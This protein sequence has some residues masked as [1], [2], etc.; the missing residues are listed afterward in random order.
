MKR[1]SCSVLIILLIQQIC[2]T[3]HKKYAKGR[4]LLPRG[5]SSNNGRIEFE[6]TIV[7]RVN[8][9]GKRHSPHK[10]FVKY[11]YN[12][13][14]MATVYYRLAA[15]GQIFRFRLERDASFLSPALNVEHIYGDFRR[16]PFSGNLQHCFYRGE[17]QG[18]P[19]ST[20]VFNLCNGL[21]GSFVSSGQRYLI[22]PAEERN[23]KIHAHL[24]KFHIVFRHS[25]L[26]DDVSNAPSTCGLVDTNK[27]LPHLR[28]QPQRPINESY[29]RRRRKRSLGE[30]FVETLVVAD[31]TMVDAFDSK[32]DL[33][34]YIITLMGV[35]AQIYRDRSIGCAINIVVV[36]IAYL[37]TKNPGFHISSDATRTLK[38]FCRW[39][40][41]HMMSEESQSHR[42]DTAILLTRRDIC[43]SPGKCDTLGLA[44]LGT[45]CQSSRSCSLAEDNGLST[46]YTIA[47][48]LGHVFSLPHDGDNNL[49][50]RSRGDQHLMAPSLSFDSK[51][52][53][54]SSCSREKI[55]R[56]LELGYGSCLENKP[57]EKNQ[58]KYHGALPG[59]IYSV[60][61]QCQMI[62]GEESRLC[63]YMEPCRRLWC[64]KMIGK[65]KGCSTHHMPWADGTPCAKRKWCIKGQCVRKRKL[66]PVDGGW[67]PW[68]S[69]N[70]CTRKCGGGISFAYRKCN[71]PIP[72]NGGKYC[73]GKR[74]RFVSCNTQECPPGSLDF[75]ALQC[76][77][78]HGRRLSIG[79]RSFRPTR[80][81][82]KYA[83]IRKENQC[84]LYC[85]MAGTAIYFKLKDKVID[86]TPCNQETTDI[87]V[88]G[89]CL[90]AGCDRDL[91]SKKKFDK[92][93]VCGGDNSSCRR[94]S[95]TFNE[96]RFGYN[97]IFTIPVAS[98]DI[99]ITQYG[100]KNKEDSSYLA[101]QDQN[102]KFLLNGGMIVGVGIR[103][104]RVPGAKVWYSGSEKA[105]EQ[106]K[107]SGKVTE[108]IKVHVLEVGDVLPPNI[109]YSFNQKISEPRKLVYMWS[110][111]G[112]WTQC[113]K[114]CRGK[115]NRQ[116][117]CVRAIDKQQVSNSRC[118]QR[119]RPSSVSE[120]CN[121]S[122]VLEWKIQSSGECSARCGAGNQTR[123]VRCMRISS[124]RWDI[125][126]DKHC[127]KG[128]KP[129]VV[130]QCE[131]KCEGTK[132]VYSEWSK[133]SKSCGRGRQ[134]RTAEC[135]DNFGEKLE[136]RDCRPSDKLSLNRHCNTFK[137]PWW[138][139]GNWTSCSVTCGSGQRTRHVTCTGEKGTVMDT[140]CNPSQRP[141]STKSCDLKKCPYWFAGKWT[142]C[143]KTCDAGFMTRRVLCQS[144]E[145]V[146]RV[147]DDIQCS[148]LA[149]PIS[150]KECKR[151]DCRTM[152][153]MFPDS[154][155]NTKYYWRYSLWTPCS[156][157]CGE[158]PG[159][160]YRDVECVKVKPGYETAVEKQ[161]LVNKKYCEEKKKPANRE[162]CKVLPCTSWK[163]GSWGRC[164]Q[165]CGWGFQLRVVKCTY[166]NWK[167]TED[168][169]C[170]QKIRPKN[171]RDCQI[172]PCK[173]TTPPPT[174]PQEKP[175]WKEGTW[176]ECSV[177]C[178]QG[179]RHREIS[180]GYDNGHIS[181][182][183]DPNS[184]PASVMEC[185]LRA[186][187]VWHEE[188]WSECSVSCGEGTRRRG[189]DCRFANGQLSLGCD[190]KKRPAIKEACNI[191]PCPTWMTGDWGSCSVTCGA[192]TKARSVECSDRDIKCDPGTKPE[193][194]SNCDLKECPQW[195]T[196]PWE[197]C[198]VSCGQGIRKRQVDCKSAD[199]QRSL[200]CDLKIKP[201]VK[202]GCNIRPC[203]SWMTGAWGKCSVTCGS[204]VKVRTVECSD[205]DVPC[206]AETKPL[207]KE[208][209]VLRECPQWITS[210]WEECSV[211][212]GEGTRQRSVECRLKTGQLSPGCDERA[213]PSAKEACNI[214]PCPTWMTG[215]WGK[216]SVTCGSGVNFRSVECSDEDIQCDI[217]TK[218]RNT[219]RCD[220]RACPRWIS[221]RWGQCSVT[222]GSGT[223][224]RSVECSDKDIS[225]DSE[226][227]PLTTERCDLK[228][229]PRWN[230]GLWGECSVS[231]GNGT[232]LRTVDCRLPNGRLSPGCDKENQPSAK[233]ACNIRPCP[234]WMTGEWG[235]CSVTCGLGVKTRS[236]ECSDIDIPCDVL[237]KPDTSKRCDLAK[238]PQWEA[239]PWGECSVTCGSGVKSR[240]VACV[241]ISSNCNTRTKPRSTLRCNNFPCPKWR[242]GLWSKCSK[243]CGKGT[244][245]RKVDCVGGLDHQC[246]P[247][248]KPASTAECDHGRCS[249]WS[250]GE[251]QKCSVT[252]GRGWQFRKVVCVGSSIR[253]CDYRNQPDI[254][255]QCNMGPCPVWQ[256]GDWETCSVSCG[257]GEKRRTVTCSGGAGNCNARNK[258]LAITSCNLG[259][260]PVWRFD[261]WSRCSVS[262]GTGRRKRI[263]YCSGGRN[264][265]DKGSKPEAITSCNL[266]KCPEWK[267]G[268]WN[269]CSV[270]CGTGI[271]ERSVECSG[272]RGKCDARIEPEA[273]TS[274]NLGTCPE[275]KFGPWSKCSVSCGN[276]KIERT[277]ECSGGRNN[278]D[279]ETKPRAIASCN[280]GSCP[281]W[282]T[283]EW[284]QCSVTCGDG[285]RRRSVSCSGGLSKCN[286]KNKPEAVSHCNLG[287]CPE[288]RTSQWSK[289]SVTCGDG[290]KK[291]SVS[292]S[293]GRNKCDSSSKPEAVSRCNLGACPEWLAAEWSQCS[294]S[295]GSGFIRRMVKCSRSD[296]AC[297][298][299]KKPPTTE[300]CILDECP[301]WQTGDWGQCSV[302]CGEGRKQRN[303]RC[304]AGLNKCNPRTRPQTSISCN[305]GVCPEWRVAE[306]SQCSS[307]CGE[308]FK[309]RVVECDGGPNTCDPRAKPTNRA[310]CNLGQCPHWKTGEWSKCSVTCEN[311]YK[312][313][314][315]ECL[316]GVK[317]TCDERTKPESIIPCK[318]GPCPR[319]NTGRWTPC[320]RTCGEGIRLRYV[321]CFSIKYSRVL[322]DE[323]ACDMTLRPPSAEA[324]KIRE[325]ADW[326]TGDW[327]EC[328]RKC[329]N[330]IRKR[331]VECKSTEQQRTLEDS[332]CA[333]KPKPF[334]QE[335]CKL[336]EC[337]PDAKW[338][339]STWGK[340][341]VYCGIGEKTRD[342]WCGTKNGEKI[343]E[344]L[345]ADE[346]KP[347]TR[348]SCNKR[349]RCGEWESGMWSECSKTCGEG[350]RTRYIRCHHQLEY[351]GNM[352]CDEERR[353]TEKQPCNKGACLPTLY[354]WQISGWS[355]CSTSCGYGKKYRNTWCVD[356]AGRQV[357]S[358][359][360]SAAE[361]PETVSYCFETNCPPEWKAGDWSEC[362]QTCGR[363]HQ[364]R[365]VGCVAK[366][367]R[368][369]SLDMQCDAQKRPVSWR[370][371]NLGRCN[372]RFWSVGPWHN[373]NVSCGRGNTSRTVICLSRDGSPVR[374]SNC[375]S[376]TTPKPETT[377]SCSMKACP[378]ASCKDLQLNAGLQVDGEQTLT[379]QGKELQV[380]CHAMMSKE[381]KEYITLKTGHSDNF[382]EIYPKRLRDPRKCPA[383]GSHI[384]AC[385]CEDEDFKLSGG[386]YFYKL[387]VDLSAMKIISEDK[388]FAVKRGLNPPSYGTAGDCYSA[389]GNCPQGRFSIN[390]K[391]T[392]IRL[393][394]KVMWGSTGQAYSQIIYRYREAEGLRV[395]G[396]CGGR[397]GTCS[398]E[399][400]GGL[401]IE[402]SEDGDGG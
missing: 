338:R 279:V 186:C 87:C 273:K 213:R 399:E 16:L 327:G 115:R 330:G 7:E 81:L 19:N 18:E 170:D 67:G 41:K 368:T 73:V 319:W 347:R 72:E 35:V 24:R 388:Q 382:A 242:T 247:T 108:P 260:C 202:E 212:C 306:W 316:S 48:E 268:D 219:Q 36:K 220:L 387:R 144:G 241:G 172:N 42:H 120:P 68:G 250:V 69:F 292:C 140:A 377:R 132:W 54:W 59:E 248:S 74:K 76:V 82:P 31:K 1:I 182:D 34:S 187:P 365:K 232:R 86:G 183:C 47:H 222:C 226:T 57:S 58:S 185:V 149:R 238:C 233:E 3:T 191:R 61:K 169:N 342:V 63:P 311:G 195:I 274:C 370:S 341:S 271:K 192:G 328:S 394:S 277:V 303:V 138:T 15:F 384:D 326:H 392:G 135:I 142:D 49:C 375:L 112:P 111:L 371:C 184:K 239:G 301:K 159:T 383:N 65:R 123:I 117:R 155:E 102:D 246:D 272:G 353:P 39:Q 235:R 223:K 119:T 11:E 397:C 362:S 167:I 77:N 158:K 12:G 287:A 322:N 337:H 357:S 150:R 4:T 5:I 236:V 255:A 199:G 376:P 290:N 88:E 349:R 294:V 369:Q 110:Q 296:V 93:G 204:G 313:R 203:P 210:P 325:C 178:G 180:C 307:S 129:A 179:E 20:A 21:H 355:R 350:I 315:V 136:D 190:K 334:V 33:E 148:P 374:D 116:P 231:C 216:C 99:V 55:T 91:S 269:Q 214:R 29:T 261:A 94:L 197:E 164:S 291:R 340:C 344:E 152:L 215:E 366:Y 83:G 153:F 147:L 321:G 104:F 259:A 329:G 200:G 317:A 141:V 133:C 218:P 6:M 278:C 176:S 385:D 114:L 56:F 254:Y 75:R 256:A 217:R 398:H 161:E 71:K 43:R 168:E 22:E 66:K 234:T 396:K 283:G 251:W 126:K 130:V 351:K 145:P 267:V 207:A 100:W 380:Y 378:P 109:H 299:R 139:K 211:S 97:Y 243:S 240:N 124:D 38:S 78:T 92:C 305:P 137:C 32:A 237:T 345:C 252:C 163:H 386:S 9:L 363:G 174:T 367:G 224:M 45:M 106:I 253:S 227:K 208:R 284:T 134:N 348:R 323:S 25:A 395:R 175:S 352:F 379:V 257:N 156:A 89:K 245:T 118:D 23:T 98:T 166:D 2:A 275:W 358:E 221:G 160:R 276:G 318:L 122:C 331:N 165:P 346:H 13:W 146:P 339:K 262:C 360:C 8:R 90:A 131:G 17:I 105:T 157:T 143:S 189:V 127:A 113:N 51:P 103:E 70:E 205:K 85:R 314:L 46:A 37:D 264:K 280:L 225:C 96:T 295:C 332:A 288:W 101:L 402:L 107:I 281:V 64:V 193:T 310:R 14:G 79:S 26:E 381:P 249:K 80:W 230:A 44:E 333:F 27:P 95:R 293:G 364:T 356:L 60:D 154:G 84:K 50:T 304:S 389:Q 28:G 372:S 53:S 30:S 343:A 258:P 162:E 40:K 10:H 309:E 228:A 359:R 52:W 125:V 244:K 265:C 320:S 229:C 390:L 373:C 266:S 121:L 312:Q 297:E 181:S 361:K 354:R 151:E 391:G 401:T 324:C 393:T 400:Y 188:P 206:D 62:F 209:C 171:R 128:S 198:S 308:G 263:V 289:C 270:S 302:T 173:S 335:D 298:S 177:T 336:R 286:P 285:N 282:I 300:R 194:I 201:A 196:S